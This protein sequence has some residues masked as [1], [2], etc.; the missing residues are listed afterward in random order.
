MSYAEDRAWS[1]QF[2]PHIRAIVGPRLLVESP[3]EVDTKQAAD[4]I[5]LKARDMT[6][7]ARVRRA[8]Y[9]ERYPWDFTLRSRRDSGAKT[10]FRKIVEGWGDWLL[11]GHE[12]EKSRLARWLLID[13]HELRAE[14]IY[15]AHRPSRRLPDPMKPIANG[16]GTHFIAYNVRRLPSRIVVASSHPIPRPQSEAA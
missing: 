15:D 9:A 13:L 2:I 10:E 16:D 5:V 4:L 1:D 8:G 6:V 12:G 11:Y 3:L 7:A 14:M